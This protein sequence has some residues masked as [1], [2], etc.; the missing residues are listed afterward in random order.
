MEELDTYGILSP[1]FSLLRSAVH[2]PLLLCSFLWFCCLEPSP[3]DLDCEDDP[4]LT[5]GVHFL[6]YS[7]RLCKHDALQFIAKPQT[8][9]PLLHRLA[10]W[11]S[12][13]SS[14]EVRSLQLSKVPC[15]YI[16]QLCLLDWFYLRW[17]ESTQSGAFKRVMTVRTFQHERNATAKPRVFQFT[18]LT[19]VPLLSAYSIGMMVLKYREGYMEIPGF[20]GESDP[21]LNFPHSVRTM[22]MLRVTCSHPYSL[23]TLVRGRPR[24]Y[25]S[26]EHGL[27]DCLGA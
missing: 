22:L 10:S 7:L 25:F 14:L 20:G 26:L 27:C 9:F 11:L 1:A 16:P 8:H 3:P 12:Y 2:L 17:G 15:F 24:I 13:I 19:A 23:S 18:Y 6:V 4:R 21:H 5:D